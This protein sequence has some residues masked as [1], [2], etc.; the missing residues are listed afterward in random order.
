MSDDGTSLRD[1]LPSRD[2]RGWTRQ[3]ALAVVFLV[4]VTGIATAAIVGLAAVDGPIPLGTDSGLTIVVEDHGGDLHLSEGRINSTARKVVSPAGNATVVAESN[5]RA[6]VRLAQ[7]LGSETHVTRANVRNTT[8]TIDPA[9]KESAAIQ[10]G[11]TELQFRPSSAVGVDDG[12]TDFEYNAD[13]VGTVEIGG[14]PAGAELGLRTTDGEPVG[15]ATADANGRA[16]FGVDEQTNLT[17]V[18]VVSAPSAPVIESASPKDGGGVSA[19]NA[20]LSA[21]VSD[22]DFATTDGDTVT[23]TFKMNGEIVGQRELT[24]NGT[25]SVD[26]EPPLSETSTWSVTVSDGFDKTDSINTRSFS[27]PAELKIYKESQPTKLVDGANTTVKVRFYSLSNETNVISRDVQNGTVNLT[28]LAVDEEFVVTVAANETTANGTD[29]VYRRIAIQSLFETSNIYLLDESV[30][31]SRVVFELQDPTG[32]FPPQNSLLYVEKAIEKDYDGDGSNE[33]RYQTIT[34]DVFG[35]SG[36]FPAILQDD[37]R[38]RLRVV[39]RETG[40]ERGLGS[41]QVYGATV[42][43]LKIQRIEPS[44]DKRQTGVIYG[45]LEGDDNTQLAVRFRGGE[46]DTTVSY[47]V[48][49]SDGNIVVPETT[50]TASAFAHQYSVNAT[51]SY[52][53][54]GTIEYANGTVVK[55]QFSAGE[56]S[57]IAGRLSIDGQVVSIMSWV[58][59]LATMGLIVIFNRRLAPAAGTGM[60][61]ALTIIGT[62]A[63]PMPLLGIAG[64][65]SVLTLFGGN[66]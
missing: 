54:N 5:G 11:V 36:R 7:T 37:E 19:A 40:Q 30:P 34:G 25:V 47:T 63:I 12:Q 22:A 6:K 38:Y 48:T 60:A 56:I 27:T 49:D 58:M 26:V 24:S 51:K 43:P 15:S 10:G 21:T 2:P 64:A 45:G 17:A 46:D 20:E 3:T 18:R 57:G 32:E 33:T 41:Y 14:L 9:D 42:E 65:I 62:V 23:A 66:Q 28:G 53:I 61:S 52:Q 50:T 29:W 16:E 13:A 39:S 59:I 55:Q 8:I 4:A 31:S 1:R 44:A 35:A